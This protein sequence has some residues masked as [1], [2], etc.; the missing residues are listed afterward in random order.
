LADVLR[1][2]VFIVFSRVVWLVTNYQ[3]AWRRPE[4]KPPGTI[5]P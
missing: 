3:R 1:F 5:C 4:L 2:F